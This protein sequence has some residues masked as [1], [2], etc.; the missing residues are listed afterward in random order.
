[1]SAEIGK[2]IV[3]ENA[4][5]Q[6][7]LFETAVAAATK[8]ERDILSSGLT[9]CGGVLP[10]AAGQLL[11]DYC[12]KVLPLAVQAFAEDETNA[13]LA[14]AFVSITSTTA[15]TGLGDCV[16][17]WFVLKPGHD[18]VW[19]FSWRIAASGPV[20]LVSSKTIALIASAM[21]THL[22]S[23]FV[24][25]AGLVT[26][27]HLATN[28]QAKSDMVSSDAL[29]IAVKVM[30][31][32]PAVL[33]IQREGSQILRGLSFGNADNKAAIAGIGGVQALVTA[34]EHFAADEIIAEA[35]TAS[36]RNLTSN[37]GNGLCERVAIAFGT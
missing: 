27:K 31:Q 13:I 28:A 6:A 15:T 25:L 2:R 18:S 33:D 34:L 3:A 37:N 20:L 35:V 12:G 7:A 16:L 9:L 21:A 29:K 14:S 11:E 22:E 10:T 23:V 1:L 30:N 26:M 8:R 24:T 36:L 17:V 19:L 4:E 5:M 32:H